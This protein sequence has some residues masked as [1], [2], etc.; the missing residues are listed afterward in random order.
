M[1]VMSVFIDNMFQADVMCHCE[2]VTL[3]TGF[4]RLH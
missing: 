3:C 1:Y 2:I 4:T